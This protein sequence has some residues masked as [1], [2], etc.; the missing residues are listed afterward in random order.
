MSALLMASTTVIPVGFGFLTPLTPIGRMFFVVYAIVGVPLTLMVTSDIGKF[1]CGFIFS[2]LDES[3]V[4][5]MLV[6]MAMLVSYPILMG[7]IISLVSP[8]KIVDS[9]VCVLDKLPGVV[10]V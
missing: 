8:M 2:L 9:L 3:P 7:L 4:R 10:F 5:S 1:I 6:L